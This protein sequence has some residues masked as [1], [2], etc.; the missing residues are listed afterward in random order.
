MRLKAVYFVILTTTFACLSG[1]E[2]PFFPE[3]HI[4]TLRQLDQES[5]QGRFC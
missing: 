4:R 2:S 5:M 1:E 3:K